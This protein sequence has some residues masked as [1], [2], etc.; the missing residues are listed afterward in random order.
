MTAPGSRVDLSRDGGVTS[1]KR[2]SPVVLD[3][4]AGD[5]RSLGGIADWA[6]AIAESG[7]F[8]FGPEAVAAALGFG[9]DGG[10]P[11]GAGHDFGGG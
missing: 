1:E 11:F 4:G 5:G 9:G 8:D 10:E 3:A 7:G 6:R 2:V